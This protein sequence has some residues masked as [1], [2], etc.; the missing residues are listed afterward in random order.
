MGIFDRLPQPDP[1]ELREPS[2]IETLRHNRKEHMLNPRSEIFTR[3]RSDTFEKLFFEAYIEE[4]P[5]ELSF[6]DF[7]DKGG[8]THS[9]VKNVVASKWAP[10][11]IIL[12]LID[13]PVICALNVRSFEVLAQGLELENTGALTRD[14][15]RRA[16]AWYFAQAI[17]TLK[18]NDPKKYAVKIAE[19]EKDL[20]LTNVKP[21]TDEEL[22]KI[23][24]GIIR[25][26]LEKRAIGK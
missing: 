17:K 15:T 6:E 25:D 21:F 12:D 22:R 5:G 16:L 24:R 8:N 2:D 20:K 26:R 14:T 10:R 11:K 19:L 18:G 3:V 13:D 7:K 1:E 9:Q 23:L 4:K